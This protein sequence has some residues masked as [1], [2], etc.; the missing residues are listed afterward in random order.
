MA[1]SEM[2]HWQRALAVAG[3][4]VFVIALMG[5]MV[6]AA[7]GGGG[8][9]AVAAASHGARSSAA[10]AGHSR[11]ELSTTSLRSDGGSAGLPASVVAHANQA[12]LQLSD[13]PAGWTSGRAPATPSRTSPWS[14]PLASCAG[15]SKGMVAI[16]PTKFS[17]PDYTSSDNTLAVEDA[18]SV[19]PTAAEARADFAAVSKP[20]TPRCMNSIGSQALRTSIQNEA[21]SGATV[22]AVSIAALAPGTY[23]SNETGYQVTIPLQSQGRQLTI[24]STEIDFVHGRYVQQLTFNGNGA[25]FPPL[26][27]VHLIRVT[28]ART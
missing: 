1:L 15:V 20:K 5:G 7:V 4:S 3:I 14:K 19:Y 21:G 24:T 28:K 12:L 22:G 23:E 10:A 13:V 9:L 11:H 6:G 18:I 25:M 2:N 27:E 26:L 17:G 8:T 16:K